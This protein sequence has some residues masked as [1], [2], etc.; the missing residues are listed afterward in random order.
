[1]KKT[2]SLF[3]CGTTIGIILT[4]NA[5]ARTCNSIYT[6]MC[7]IT[8]GE[9]NCCRSSSETCA[10]A[11]CTSSSVITPIQPTSCPDEC[12]STLWQDVSGQNYQVKCDTLNNSCT[13]QCKAGYYGLNSSCTQ[14]PSNGTSEAGSK[15]ITSCYLPDGATAS[16]STGSWAVD[17]GKCYYSSLVDRI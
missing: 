6:V 13:Y 11:G 14:C 16:D 8:N 15:F 12:P 9:E 4:N 10:A 3:L 2:I 7:P 1:M 5:V 17:G